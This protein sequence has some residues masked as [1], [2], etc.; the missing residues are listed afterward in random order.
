MGAIIDDVDAISAAITARAIERA[1]STCRRS[2]GS[3]A[4]G[5]WCQNPDGSFLS[6]PPGW[7]AWRDYRALGDKAAPDA[8]IFRLPDMPVPWHPR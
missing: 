8:S 1:A 6:C 3:G 4:T 7:E 2:Y 5:C